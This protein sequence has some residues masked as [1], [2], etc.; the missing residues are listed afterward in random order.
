[1]SIVK[2]FRTR[3]EGAFDQSRSALDRA[4]KDASAT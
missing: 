3:A 2:E 1:M 4:Q